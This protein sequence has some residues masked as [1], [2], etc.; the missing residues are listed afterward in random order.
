MVKTQEIIT[1]NTR[2]GG[3]ITSNDLRI[4]S[5]VL[6]SK[7]LVN[8]DPEKVEQAINKVLEEEGEALLDFDDRFIQLQNRILSLKKWNPDQDW[9]DVRTSELLKSNRSWLAAYT[10]TI[11]KP[12]DFKKINLTEALL[13]Y[14]GWEKQQLLNQLAPEKLNVPTGSGIRLQYFANG[15]AP[16]LAVRLQEMFGLQDTPMVNNGKIATLLH[17]LSPGYKPV[18]V[19]ADLRSFWNNTYHEVK[20]ELK[21]RYPKH[22]WPD[23]PW[24]AVPVA[25][26]RSQKI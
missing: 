6:Q 8:P 21:R 4:G 2:R 20:K 5:I 25:K 17:L 23:D 13:N 26:G 22:A 10:G 7:P 11:K 9:P 16:V 12:E 3:L 14:L 1:W 18:Q 24:T 15:A 19:T